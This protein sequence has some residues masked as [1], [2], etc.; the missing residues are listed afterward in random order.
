MAEKTTEQPL[1][2][3]DTYGTLHSVCPYVS[4]IYVVEYYSMFW[5]TTSVFDQQMARLYIFPSYCPTVSEVLLDEK[6][7]LKQY[8]FPLEPI[9]RL[10]W[11]DPTA[12]HLMTHEVSSAW[13]C[14]AHNHANV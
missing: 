14:E 8:P 10:H 3:P 13:L 4:Y 2:P 12:D 5:V 11:D 6:T 1:R 9:P 7:G